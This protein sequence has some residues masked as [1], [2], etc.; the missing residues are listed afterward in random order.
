MAA[1]RVQ[2]QHTVAVHGDR[3]RTA[4]TTQ[5]AV[6]PDDPSPAGR[7]P[8]EYVGLWLPTTFSAPPGGHGA[9]FVAFT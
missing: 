7:V 4:D 1:V 9:S 6:R 8:F 2:V 5:R 3:C